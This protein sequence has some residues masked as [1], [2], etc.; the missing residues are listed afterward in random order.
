MGKNPPASAAGIRDVGLVSGSGSSP[1]GGHGN[2]LQYF[3]IENVV[4]GGAW[5]AIVH[6]G[7]TE[8]DMT[9]AP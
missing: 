2:P 8:S 7:H 1:G 9:V 3:Q 4:D 5:W 6:R